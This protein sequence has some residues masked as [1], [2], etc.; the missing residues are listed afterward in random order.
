MNKLVF[1]EQRKERWF[2]ESKDA[3]CIAS[4]NLGST[5]TQ[6]LGEGSGDRDVMRNGDR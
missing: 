5:H 3:V 2:S 1:R 6:G 4:K